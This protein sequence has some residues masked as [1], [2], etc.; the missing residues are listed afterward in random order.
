MLFKK[1]ISEYIDS[2]GG[3][4]PLVSTK[5]TFSDYLG[6][7][8]VRLNFSR[9][10]Y[11]VQPGLYAIGQPDEHAPVLVTANYK[12]SFDSLRKEL[13]AIN[14]WILVLDTKA[15][16][17]WCAAGKGTFGTEE[18]ILKIQ[19]TELEKIVKHR[20]VIVPQ[21]GAPGIAAHIV[22]MAT[23]FKVIYGPIQAADLPEFLQ[24]GNKATAAMRKV[25]FNLS[26]RIR[27]IPV[28]VVTGFKYLLIA[29]II[30][31]A[32]TAL[33]LNDFTWYRLGQSGSLVTIF[34]VLAYTSG[35]ILTP[36]FLLCLPARTFSMKGFLINLA[37]FV[38]FGTVAGI[39]SNISTVET[40][41]WFFMTSAIASFLAMNFT[42]ATPYTSLSGVKKEMRIA[43]PLQITGFIIGFIFWF[44]IQL[45]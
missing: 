18:L 30:F 38:L 4:I 31:L 36:L 19:S 45:K 23:G 6:A 32:I 44:I 9:K 21:L 14:A 3:K 33:T 43:M 5:W 10:N 24:N 1:M 22:K 27:V 42:G 28:E 16:N 35:T 7:I 8:K 20:Q 12:L 17:V 26:D 13:N 39:F 41:S 2:P 37:A 34:L 29:A 11:A 15:I 25:Q 40:L